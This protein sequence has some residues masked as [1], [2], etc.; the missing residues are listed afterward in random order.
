MLA[1]LR[2]KPYMQEWQK[3][4]SKALVS[5]QDVHELH[6]PHHFLKM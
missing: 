3:D 2:D 5:P 6:L 4:N 1:S